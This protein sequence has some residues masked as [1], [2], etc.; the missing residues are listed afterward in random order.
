MNFYTMGDVI[1]P[2]FENNTLSPEPIPEVRYESDLPVGWIDPKQAG[3]KTDGTPLIEPRYKTDYG[4]ITPI[5]QGLIA[6]EATEVIPLFEDTPAEFR[7]AVESGYIPMTTD[8]GVQWM[9]TLPAKARRE[10]QEKVNPIP[11]M[12]LGTAVYLLLGL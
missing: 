7:Q 12:I 1:I 3:L 6:K 4:D 5:E 9:E 8:T 11:G 2:K 10:A